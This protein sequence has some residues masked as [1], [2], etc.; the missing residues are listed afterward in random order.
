[1]LD[2]NIMS[3]VRKFALDNSEK[4]DIYGFLRVED[5]LNLYLQL[6]TTFFHF[7]LTNN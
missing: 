4:D 6:G 7:K 5:I 2:K 3:K 1:M